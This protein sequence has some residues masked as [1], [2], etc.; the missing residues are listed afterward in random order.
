MIML[1]IFYPLVPSLHSERWV[2]HSTTDYA[3]GV[4]AQAGL[5]KPSEAT[6]TKVAEELFHEFQSTGLISSQPFFKRAHRW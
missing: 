3:N 4:I 5:L 1:I 2:L 6:L